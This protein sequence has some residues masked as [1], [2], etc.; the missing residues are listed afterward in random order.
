[1]KYKYETFS[2]LINYDIF[3]INLFLFLKNIQLKTER[4]LKS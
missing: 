4:L 1:M 2:K 3:E